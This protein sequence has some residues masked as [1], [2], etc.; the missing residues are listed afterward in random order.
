MVVALNTQTKNSTKTDILMPLRKYYENKQLIP[1]TSFN[2]KKGVFTLTDF[3]WLVI[4]FSPQKCNKTLF[5]AKVRSMG[6]LLYFGTLNAEKFRA[7]TNT[8]SL[9]CSIAICFSLFVIVHALL[10]IYSQLRLWQFNT[11][12]VKKTTETAFYVVPH[13]MS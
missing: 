1:A 3:F 13:P 7:S 4:Y 2:E 12:A 5:F 6:L 9:V 10:F 11:H 8:S